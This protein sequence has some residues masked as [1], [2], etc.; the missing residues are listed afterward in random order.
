VTE[1]KHIH[2][3]QTHPLAREHVTQSI[4]VWIQLRKKIRKTLVM[5]LKG[6]GAKTN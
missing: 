3:K 4:T 5:I 2:E 1:A 6:L